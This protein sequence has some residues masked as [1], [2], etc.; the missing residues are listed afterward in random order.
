MGFYRDGNF[1]PWDDEIDIDIF[2]EDFAP[3]FH[4][5]ASD[6]VSLG[7]IVRTTFRGESSKMALFYKGLKTAIGGVYLDGAKPDFRQGVAYQWPVRFYENATRFEYK[8]K[9]F[10]LPGPMDEYL[11][12][13]YGKNWRTPLVSDDPEE[14][15]SREGGQFKYPPPT[16]RVRAVL[17]RL[18]RLLTS[19]T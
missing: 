18:K 10:L 14:Y 8:G 6:F 1:I 2:S 11:T 9:T 3:H 4:K 13:C 19:S 16:G 17:S 12:F 5:I 7:F 15:M